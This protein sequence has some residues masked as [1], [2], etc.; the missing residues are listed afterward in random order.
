MGKSVNPLAIYLCLIW[1]DRAERPISHGKGIGDPRSTSL[2]STPLPWRPAPP[3]LPSPNPVRF[4]RAT[5]SLLLGIR[6]FNFF[7]RKKNYASSVGLV[8]ILFFISMFFW[9]EM[10]T[11]IGYGVWDASFGLLLLIFL[12]RRNGFSI[13]VGVG[14]FLL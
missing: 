13:W 1:E 11:R 4:P 5:T 10:R 3:P 9:L 14:V 6:C 8:F 12:F 2:H 7:K